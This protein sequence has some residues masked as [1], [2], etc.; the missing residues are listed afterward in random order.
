VDPIGSTIIEKFRSYYGFWP[1]ERYLRYDRNTPAFLQA[2]L[3]KGKTLGNPFY[4]DARSE[5]EEAADIYKLLVQKIMDSG[6]RLIIGEYGRFSW[7][8][9]VLRAQA[10]DRTCVAE[11]PIIESFPY[12]A[13]ESH[14][15]P[16]GN[17]LVAEQFFS[18][19]TGAPIEAKTVK[20][21]NP[22]PV[23][24]NE[25][26]SE[27]VSLQVFDSISVKRGDQ[28][29]GEFLSLDFVPQP[30][31]FIADRGFQSL[32]AMRAP[33]GIAAGAIFLGLKQSPKSQFYIDHAGDDGSSSVLLGAPK[34]LSGVT[35]IDEIAL[36]GLDK[37]ERETEIYFSRAAAAEYFD[38]GLT[39]G[40]ITFRLGNMIL[41]KGAY[42][43]DSDSFKL[44]PVNAD[45]FIV[46]ST[47]ASPVD[48]AELS[49]DVDLVLTKGKR[50]LRTTL[51]E[52]QAQTTQL[53][54]FDQCQ[55]GWRP[56]LRSISV[57]GR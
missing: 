16:V 5:R 33:Q 8:N 56:P 42:D 45:I 25:R 26:Y 22:P 15:S 21:L 24:D 35:R 9:D 57:S 52:F 28:V 2:I 27:R 32:L 53:R 23:T 4:Y 46:R 7:L 51:A 10:N 38:R 49:G 13:P 37:H 17:L 19:L 14:N 3:P 54:P 50:E 48:P 6:V 31:S 29:I 44:K 34:P 30:S 39:G 40:T 36:G 1:S 55:A 20:T 12:I 11:L 43:A 41:L 18:L 47:L